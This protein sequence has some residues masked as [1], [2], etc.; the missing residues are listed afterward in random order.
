MESL[1]T[2]QPVEQ[3]NFT[4][5]TNDGPD[6]RTELSVWEW[7]RLTASSVT[8]LID[9]LDRLA[10]LRVTRVAIDLT[11]VI[12]LNELPAH[13]AQPELARLRELLQV[14]C[15]A[16][17][18][19]GISVSAAAGDPY[20]VEDGG[21]RTVE[22]IQRFVGT[23][24]AIVSPREQITG[25]QLDVEPW[26]HRDWDIR[27]RELSVRFLKLVGD[28]ARVQRMLLPG[29][30]LSVAVAHW[31]DGTSE[32]LSIS[33]RSEVASVFAHLCRELASPTA[34]NSVIVMAYR[35]Q[36]HGPD[37]SASL[38][39]NE[40]EVPA[41]RAHQV[42]IVI[43]QELTAVRPDKTTFHELGMPALRAAMN[44]LSVWYAPTRALGG[45]ALND[46]EELAKW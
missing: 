6:V 22:M 36:A 17:S 20:W 26:A 42:K 35:S 30:A 29:I 23:Y 41:V 25:F 43:G 40:F 31:L 37:G 9:D 1:Q 11:L 19:R 46:A 13:H 28:A 8:K 2:E 7:R 14:Y 21:S 33:Y 10:E 16:A 32:P 5:A 27:K 45:F 38:L 18:E 39:A 15:A 4:R 44:Q 24:N 34:A 3:R 12:D